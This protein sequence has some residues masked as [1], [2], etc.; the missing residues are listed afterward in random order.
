MGKDDGCAR[1]FV[2]FVGAE[3]R[4]LSRSVEVSK[5]PVNLCSSTLYSDK[6]NTKRNEDEEVAGVEVQGI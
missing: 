2:C 1:L 3:A 5:S 4:L 6:S